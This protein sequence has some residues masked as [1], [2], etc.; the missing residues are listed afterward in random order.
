M[1]CRTLPAAGPAG[2]G[3]RDRVSQRRAATGRAASWCDE[4]WADCVD[5]RSL[6]RRRGGMPMRTIARSGRRDRRPPPATG[7]RN[8]RSPAC[9][10]TSV[11]DRPRA[12]A[13]SGRVRIALDARGSV[14]LRGAW[15]ARQRRASARRMRVRGV[16]RCAAREFS[17]R[18]PLCGVR[19]RGSAGNTR[20]MKCMRPRAM[21]P[22]GGT[23]NDVV[24]LRS[25]RRCG[26]RA[27]TG[28]TRWARL[29]NNRAAAVA[30]GGLRCAPALPA[31]GLALDVQV[32]RARAPHGRGCRQEAHP[33][34]ARG[35]QVPRDLRRARRPAPD[36]DRHRHAVAAPGARQRGRAAHR[37][38][39][40][41]Q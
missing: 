13:G 24:L 25:P 8:A 18:G 23:R 14:P 3:D 1:R 36:P 5:V 11:G 29:W 16:A 40:Q 10:V 2:R 30:L 28:R 20:D 39:A 15:R 34:G 12:Y 37:G 19:A 7:K 9:V 41:D 32:L 4:C 31:D 35:P 21:R 27:R 26:R 17:S 38:N 33:R 6:N 22:R